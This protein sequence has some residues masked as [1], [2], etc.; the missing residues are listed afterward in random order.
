MNGN[1]FPLSAKVVVYIMVVSCYRRLRKTIVLKSLTNQVIKASISISESGPMLFTAKNINLPDFVHIVNEDQPI[2]YITG[3]IDLSIELILERDRGYH[4]RHLDTASK[5]RNHRGINGFESRS[6]NGNVKRS[7]VND[8]VKYGD[9]SD[10][11]CSF[12]FPID[13]T[14]TPVLQEKV[15]RSLVVEKEQDKALADRQEE[16]ASKEK[17]VPQEVKDGKKKVKRTKVSASKGKDGM[18]SEEEVKKEATASLEKYQKKMEQE[19]EKAPK[20]RA[21]KFF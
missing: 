21:S 10:E 2:A 13:S 17:D 16:G 9:Y 19:R 6:F 15:I 8:N 7:V 5:I 3:P 11:N 20:K 14:F 18:L 1:L 4:P 12:T